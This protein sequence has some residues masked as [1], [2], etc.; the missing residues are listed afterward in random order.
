MPVHRPSKIDRLPAELRD[1][2][3]EMRAGG[4]TIDEILQNLREVIDPDDMPSRSGLGRHIQ[5]VDAAAELIDAG[6]K[7]AQSILPKDDNASPMARLNREL[8]HGLTA[9]L[10]MRLAAPGKEGEEEVTLSAQEAMFIG[11]MLKDVSSSEQ[12]D[13]RTKQLLA[14]AAGE[15]TATS[16]ASSEEAT[17]NIPGGR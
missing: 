6:R 5:N 7:I 8:L 10:L 2:I 13:L 4:F 15:K 12:L 9:K 3:V 14:A 16:A 1:K 17:F 11:R